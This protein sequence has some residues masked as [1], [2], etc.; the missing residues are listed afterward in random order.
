MK[1]QLRAE[2][3]RQGQNIL[4]KISFNRL[5]L[6]QV[7]EFMKDNALTLFFVLLLCLLPWWSNIVRL[8]L[9]VIYLAGIYF[10]PLLT[11]KERFY[12][13]ATL[14]NWLNDQNNMVILKAKAQ[15]FAKHTKA[16]MKQVHQHLNDQVQ[17]AKTKYKEKQETTVVAQ[18]IEE[19]SADQF[20]VQEQPKAE[21]QVQP[22][23]QKS[24]FA[25]NTEII[26][27]IIATIIGG[28]LVFIFK[29]S[30][31][32][33]GLQLTSIISNGELSSDGLYY[34]LG[35][36]VLAMGI[37]MTVGGLVKA[38]SRTHSGGGIWKSI[39]LICLAI[40]CVIVV[41]FYMNPAEVIGMTMQGVASSEMSLSEA[42]DVATT[43]PKIIDIIPWVIILLYII[44]IIV[45]VTKK[46][47]Q[48]A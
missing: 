20:K 2:R 15:S 10:Y 34:I 23:V 32:S 36:G 42:Y 38:F 41:Y 40:I 9:F 5:H 43:L 6:L 8:V 48:T 27:G 37:M 19:Q 7:I 13:D 4:S 30:V 12:W 31:Y 29:D 11:N 21:Q 35:Y 28:T 25:M 46:Q 16:G 26:V 3:K 33:M 22:V 45:N 1:M 18:P 39:S 24:S 17:E 14:E 47:K 44:G